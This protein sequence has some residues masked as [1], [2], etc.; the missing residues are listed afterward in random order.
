MKKILI[1]C[2]LLIFLVPS[3]MADALFSAEVLDT[4]GIPC[5]GIGRS[6]WWQNTL[7]EIKILKCYLWSGFTTGFRGD[8]DARV[9]CQRAYD[10]LLAINQWGSLHRPGIAASWPCI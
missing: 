3:V 9:Y 5:D 2:I 8:A 4:T 1:V 10:V 7:G 6:I